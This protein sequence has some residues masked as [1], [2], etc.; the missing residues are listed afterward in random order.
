MSDLLW[1]LLLLF[2]AS[3]FLIGSVLARADSGRLWAVAWALLTAA[4]A[5][6]VWSER[7]PALL[8]VSYAFGSL[9]PFAIVAG[10]LRY[11]GQPLPR[12]GMAAAL[13]VAALRMALASLGIERLAAT[14]VLVIDPGLLVLAAALVSRAARG[15]GVAHR[16]MAPGFALLAVVEA[17]DGYVQVGTSDVAAVPWV[18]WVAVS[19]PLIGFQLVAA[20]QTLAS[21]HAR[22]EQALRESEAH[23]RDAERVAQLGSFT[24]RSGARSTLCSEE[25]RRLLGLELGPEVPN[26]RLF[27][28][29][30]AAHQARAAE[31]YRTAFRS[32]EP[33]ET[34]VAVMLDGAERRLQ[35]RV[36][37]R[38]SASGELLG[39]SGTL[40][41]VTEARRAAEA[42]RESEERLRVILSSLVNAR[43]AVVDRAGV[44]REIYGSDPAGLRY[45]V[46]MSASLHRSVFAHYHPDDVEP[47]R[48][49]L[50]EVFATGESRELR[51]RVVTP[52]GTFWFDACVSPLRN[53][54]GEV[55]EVLA[56]G[57]DITEHVRAEEER[58]KFEARLVQ[59]QRLESLGVL[60]G[61][62]AHDFNN[63]LVG[64]LGNAELALREVGRDGAAFGPLCDM[65]SAA[66]RAAGLTR[67]LLA[68]AG[69]TV[70]SPHPFDL[71]ALVA[72]TLPLLHTS[73]PAGTELEIEAAEQGPWVVAD[74]G[75]IGQV[76]LNLVSNA[77]EAL[78]EKGGGIRVR[79][80][81]VHA[82]ASLLSECVLTAQPPPGEFACVEV[83]DTGA[84]IAP[85]DIPRVFDP[86]YTTKFQGRGLGLAA[87]LGIVR[88]HEGAIRVQSEVGRGST[89][90]VLLP[91]VPEAAAAAALA[92][93]SAPSAHGATLLVVDDEP[94]VR[95][96][97]ARMLRNQGFEAIEAG[98]ARQALE[99]FAAAQ[100]EIDGAL[101]DLTMPDMDGM[102]LV[103]ALREL[104]PDLPIVLMSGHS[105]EDALERMAGRSH[106]TCLPKPFGLAELTGA[107]GRVLE[108][109]AAG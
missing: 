42:Q 48:R 20:L 47:V 56:L 22:A 85:E 105:P 102:Q 99:L 36:E 18:A 109:G 67:Q 96:T 31:L 2:A 91:A 25:T 94:M 15:R 89:F 4:G 61:G 7:V 80:S 3:T 38:L 86:F 79:T 11:A 33:A 77:A 39:V 35:V 27:A 9:F 50:A 103:D 40:R 49:A 41:D 63:L 21:T 101:L 73:L 46:P 23:L 16:A 59:S 75:Q 107:L 6:A 12:W 98:S 58:R 81:L 69:K 65:R 1:L 43:M 70:V 108:K 104:R 76:V 87:V 14:L 93:A 55:R 72:E 30:K 10:A 34:E 28:A 51:H 106:A 8:S 62:I 53:P 82:D 13:A 78:G 92:T 37:P 54:S 84:G 57:R 95:N 90:Q 26:E 68:Y 19:L 60:A 17:Y 32:L 45:G 97:A 24:W 66:A 83:S 71:A 29:V 64:I 44:I 88:S 74:D 52:G 5:C 100:D